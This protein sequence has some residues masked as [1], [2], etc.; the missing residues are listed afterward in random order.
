MSF[1][2]AAHASFVVIHKTRCKLF[3]LTRACFFVYITGTL[4][5]AIAVGALV[6]FLTTTV[7]RWA[8][9]FSPHFVADP[10]FVALTATALACEVARCFLVVFDQATD[11]LIYAYSYEKLHYGMVAVRLRASQ[12]LS[13]LMGDPVRS[14]IGNG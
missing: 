13:A 6:Y 1:Y 11:T 4:V 14:A 7:S 5:V 9:E 8:D 10:L 12:P 2:P 3:I